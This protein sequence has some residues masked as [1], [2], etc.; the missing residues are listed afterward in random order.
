MGSR[1][2]RRDWCKRM[3]MRNES[4]SGLFKAQTVNGATGT[5]PHY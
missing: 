4:G 1:Q 2:I 5:H 3:E